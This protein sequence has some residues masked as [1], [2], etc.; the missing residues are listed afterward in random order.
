[1]IAAIVAWGVAHAAAIA[2]FTALATAIYSGEKVVS[3]AIEI[4]QQLERAHDKPKPPAD[5]E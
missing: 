1:M 3:G 5:A 2:V 4:E